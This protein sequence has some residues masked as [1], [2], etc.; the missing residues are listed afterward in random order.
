MADS[1]RSE[2]QSAAR[3]RT[4]WANEESAGIGSIRPRSARKRATLSGALSVA[5]GS[6]CTF[7]PARHKAKH[8]LANGG[9]RLRGSRIMAAKIAAAG[10]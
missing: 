9:R 7:V 1:T 5:P 8:R 2:V 3:S 6:A 4:C 10:R